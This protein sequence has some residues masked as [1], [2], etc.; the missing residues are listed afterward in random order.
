VVATSKGRAFRGTVAIRN[1]DVGQ[2]LA[3]TTYVR[4]GQS[5]AANQQL[6][7]RREDLRSLIND[8]IKQRSGE[9]E[10][11]Y[12]IRPKGLAQALDRRHRISKE[13]A[14]STMQ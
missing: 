2:K 13:H 5:L 8:R 14:A 7:Q 1:T 9:P 3:S 10:D 6:A 4:N 11:C 12:T